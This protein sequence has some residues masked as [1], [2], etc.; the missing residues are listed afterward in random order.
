MNITFEFFSFYVWEWFLHFSVLEWTESNLSKIN[1]FRGI[2]LL[3][4]IV[5]VSWGRFS[6]CHTPIR[7]ISAIRDQISIL[8]V[9]C[10]ITRFA[11][12]GIKDRLQNK[13]ISFCYFFLVFRYVFQCLYPSSCSL[14][15][16][17]LSKKQ[18]K[19][20]ISSCYCL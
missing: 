11:S 8:I 16:R 20:Y 13:V 3:I 2:I 7:P 19:G 4:T 14:C 17:Y 15:L 18:K 5:L 9:G 12:V 10:V 1:W 6:L